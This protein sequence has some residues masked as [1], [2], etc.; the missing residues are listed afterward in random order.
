MLR[1]QKTHDFKRRLQSDKWAF[2]R[3]SISWA[4]IRLPNKEVKSSYPKLIYR[5]RKATKVYNGPNM[6]R[7]DTEE[8]FMEAI[9]KLNSTQ[10]E[11]VDAIEGPVMVIAGPGTGKTQIIA[12]RIAN[13]LNKTDTKPENILA[14]TF[15]D[16]GAHAM[17]ERLRRYIGDAAYRVPVHTFH[18]FAGQLIAKYP[19]AYPNI[20]GGRPST[21]IERLGIIESIINSG[22]THLSSSNMNTNAPDPDWRRSS[23]SWPAKSRLGQM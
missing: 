8:T 17:K 1:E 21:D 20:I 7:G 12:L 9:G 5:P 10:R 13:I 11:A 4:I 15:T 3:G 14:L 18:S 6:K 19:D 16:A 22:P 2:M 23:W